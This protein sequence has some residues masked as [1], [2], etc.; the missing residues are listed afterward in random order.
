V[1][2]YCLEPNRGRQRWPEQKREQQAVYANRRRIQGQRGLR[3]LRLR[4][5]KLKRWNQHL[6]DRGGMRRVHLRGREN[7]LKRL[8]VHSGAANLGLLMRTLFGKGTPRGFQGRVQAAFSSSR[9]FFRLVA[10]SATLFRIFGGWLARGPLNA[11]TA[12]A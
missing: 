6:Y 3:L 1:R 4:G 10:R 7:I 11:V 2:T 5:E 12:A 9:A 8:V